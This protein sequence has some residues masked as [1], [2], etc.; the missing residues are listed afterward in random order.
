MMPSRSVRTSSTSTPA[1][2]A[3]DARSPRCCRP[4]A[5]RS[6][7][8]SRGGRL[9]RI[10]A[11]APSSRGSSAKAAWRRSPGW[12][13]PSPREVPPEHGPHVAGALPEMAH[14]GG[15]EARVHET[16]AAA[17]VPPALPVVPVDARPERLPRGILPL[18]DQ[19]AGALPAAGRARRVSPRRARVV[20]QAGGELEKERRREEAVPLGEREDATELLVRFVAIEEVVLRDRLVVVAGR[21]EHA[22]HADALEEPEHLLD[23][24]DR[25]LAVDGRVG[26]HVVAEPLALPDH[27]DGAVEHAGAGGDEIVGLAHAVHVY[28]DR[29]PAVGFPAPVE[30]TEQDAVRAELDVPAPS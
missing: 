5:G 24:V 12:P 22:V 18:L 27:L 30:A 1:R 14:D 11:C 7:R 13:L 15:F 10:S 28:V 17:R 8:G 16:V 21:H 3:S 19:V 9:L 29:Q 6:P 2:C 23:L 4:G 26:A 25:R 20:A